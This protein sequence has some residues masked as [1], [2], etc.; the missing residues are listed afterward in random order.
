MFYDEESHAR[1]LALLKNYG[2]HSI[3]L[4][5]ES[6]AEGDVLA[7]YAIATGAQPMR[8]T[9]DMPMIGLAASASE[10]AAEALADASARTP[11]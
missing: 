7:G 2:A 5:M 4:T 3:M 10:E 9:A 8:L 6:T 1:F 11:G